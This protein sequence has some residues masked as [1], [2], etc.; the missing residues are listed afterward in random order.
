MKTMILIL[1]ILLAPTVAFAADG[2]PAKKSAPAAKAPAKAVPAP[3]AVPVPAKVA[4]PET[5]APVAAVKPVEPE[6]A[7]PTGKV[8]WWEVLVKH[9]MELGFLLLSLV[10]AAFVRVLGKKY[11]FMDHTDKVN[12]ILQ[13]AVGY[14]EQKAVK[15][16]KLEEGK[17]TSGAEKMQLAVQFA[18]K[19]AVDYKVKEKGTSWWEEKLE[20]WLGVER[21]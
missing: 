16:T 14:A 8:V 19:L 3:K 13:R 9:A 20:S 4:D 11:G 6:K 15:A 7:A 2:A 17:Q 12:D 5:K 18:E 1:S 10:I 21:Q